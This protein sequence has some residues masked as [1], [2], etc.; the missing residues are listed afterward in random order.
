MV[1]GDMR[2][3]A[4]FIF[5]ITGDARLGFFYLLGVLN[6]E[7]VLHTSASP[8]VVIHC[9]DGMGVSNAVHVGDAS[10]HYRYRASFAN[11]SIQRRSSS[12]FIRPL[13]VGVPR[14]RSS[15]HDHGVLLLRLSYVNSCRLVD[16]RRV[17]A[18]HRVVV[19]FFSV[20]DL[21]LV[22]VAVGRR[23]STTRI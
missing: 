11:E 12:W 19:H 16:V 17:D 23:R 22:V 21:A 1:E 10:S 2:L 6:V 3:R 15:W 8:A 9:G 13:H 20:V 18:Y 5:Y 7:D 4:V 14:L